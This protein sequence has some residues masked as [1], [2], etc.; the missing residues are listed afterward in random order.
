M[1]NLPAGRPFFVLAILIAVLMVTGCVILIP[2]TSTRYVGDN[3]EL[4]A[5]FITEQ[6]PWFEGYYDDSELQL[7][8]GNGDDI[9]LEYLRSL[10]N[11]GN[12]E[13]MQELTWEIVSGPGYFVGTP[14]TIF[15]N[16][17]QARAVITSAEVGR[18]VV[19]V[20]LLWEELDPAG[21]G[22]VETSSDDMPEIGDTATAEVLWVARVAAGGA[23]Y[24]VWAVL[25]AGLMAGASLVLLRRRR[26]Q[27]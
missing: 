21:F 19:K 22:L 9:D 26:A 24:P 8:M 3:H 14:D 12:S 5:I 6:P 4:T 18:T 15:D 20:R 25:M 7:L 10:L 27:I 2:E 11:E 16:N 17:N 13:P 1:R 23:A